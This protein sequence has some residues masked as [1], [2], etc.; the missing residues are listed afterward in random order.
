[1]TGADTQS[2][3]TDS[4]PVPPVLEM[5]RIV[6]E[7]PGV[8]A[9]RDVSLGVAAGE[10]LAVVGENGAGKSTLMRVAAGV[11]PAHSYSGVVRLAG[12][13]LAPRSVADAERA[14]ISLVSQEVQI[15]PEMTVA[16]NIFLNRE[17]GFPLHKREMEAE[18]AELLSAFG[19]VIDPRMA[20]RRLGVGQR[21]MVML[22]R[23][24]A[25]QARVVIFDE[26][27]ASLSGRE[28]EAFFDMVRRLA[29]ANVACVF[30][31]HRIDEVF[32]IADRIAVMRNGELVSILDRRQTTPREVVALM[33]GR[34]LG[35]L[36]RRHASALGPVVLE[37]NH[38]SVASPRDPDRLVVSD[39]SLAVR[40]GEI[41][42]L[43]GL[44]GAG[45][46]ELAST[47]VGA[48]RGK[49]SGD[50][51]VMGSGAAI[52]SPGDAAARGLTLLTED[53]RRYGLFA[54]MNVRDNVNLGSLARVSRW[55]VVDDGQALGRTADLG[56]QLR[57]R[58]PGW[59]APVMNLSG[60]NQQKVLLARLLAMQPAV[61]I[62]DEPTRGI[63]VGAKA[64][65]FELLDGLTTRGLGVLLISSEL[66]EV[67]AMSDRVV[68]LYKGHVTAVF[69][70]RP[71]DERLLLEA[72]TGGQSHAPSEKEQ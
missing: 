25:H 3:G 40:A 64:E 36:Y 61:L 52:R 20:I 10:V 72:A 31:S 4:A 42:G 65:I 33:V 55:Q 19:L 58:A 14:G 38:V 45:R 63:D 39:V 26:P 7:F 27:T 43:F 1:M 12:E 24:R 34:D 56:T 37:L 32:E 54:N 21:Q 49:H 28:V 6:K 41:V 46:T 67:A 71:F 16:E 48:W 47:L 51:K 22:A 50:I 8:R 60:G 13:A 18:A 29:A 68:V 59:L 44:L 9:V 35:E 30:V 66:H 62:L 69:D 17:V 5:E 11:Y 23:A 53:R 2:L 57:I 15:V 70:R